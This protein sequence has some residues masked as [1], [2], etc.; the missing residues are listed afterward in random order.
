MRGLLKKLLLVRLGSW[1]RINRPSEGPVTAWSPAGVSVFVC[2]M[3]G[4]S[5][6]SAVATYPLYEYND[7]VMTVP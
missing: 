1:N 7:S 4:R 3:V 6:M 5:G 2:G